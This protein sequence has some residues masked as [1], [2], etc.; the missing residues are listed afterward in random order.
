MFIASLIL[1]SIVIFTALILVFRNIMNQN[2]VL[3]TKHIEELSEEYAEKEKDINRQLEEVKQKSQEMVSKA[4]EEARKLKVDM[5]KQ[6]EQE[7]DEIIAQARTQSEGIMEQA[8]KSRHQLLAEV[9][10]KI[11]KAAV[12]KACE[13]IQETLPDEF[14]QLVHSHWAQELI[15]DGFSRLEGLRIPEDIHEAGVISAFALNDEQRKKIAKKLK[16][17]LGR[18]ITLKEEVD[19]KVVAGI[20]VTIGSL[21][22]DGSLQNKILEK[23]R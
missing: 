17:S 2:V 8:D 5:I 4:E 1:L 20:V 19:P 9:E 21:V 22:L 6:A 18:E 15:E 16:N 7:R 23:A 3:A 14:K 11:A 12:S 13:L 10:G